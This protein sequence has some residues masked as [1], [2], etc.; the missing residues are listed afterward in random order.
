MLSLILCAI[1]LQMAHWRGLGV[2]S[3]VVLAALMHFG[4]ASAL[5]LM[6][7]ARWLFLSILLIY[8]FATPGEYVAG[9]PDAF[10]PTYEGIE[11]GLM[12]ALRLAVMLGALSLVLATSSREQ[13]MSGI[14][15][16]LRPFGLLIS[17]ERFAARLWLTLHYAET[18]PKS[19]VKHLK[20]QGWNLDA[21]L[22]AE[23]DA[24]ESVTLMCPPF[25]I[26]DGLA[27]ALW[28][29]IIWSLS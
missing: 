10:A 21:L 14:Y 5:K 3:L 23:Q 16:L 27:L 15:V 4:S 12:Q 17:P 19:I 9:F 13:F 8:A 24:P 20:Q 7:R 6:K 2:M 11:S 18:M 25:R 26:Y 1:A 28:V 22:N 29:P